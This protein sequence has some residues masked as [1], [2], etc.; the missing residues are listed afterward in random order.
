MSSMPSRFPAP[1]RPTAQQQQIVDEY[2][3][4]Y[5]ANQFIGE[6]YESISGGDQQ[7]PATPSLHSRYTGPEADNSHVTPGNFQPRSPYQASPSEY[8]P[9]Q[10]L[11]SN[12]IA[13]DAG[14]IIQ[15][16]PTPQSRQSFR[17]EDLH[18]NRPGFHQPQSQNSYQPYAVGHSPHLQGLDSSGNKSFLSL[19][20]EADHSSCRFFPPR[21]LSR[22]CLSPSRDGSTKVK[23]IPPAY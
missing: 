4:H 7:I 10:Q 12:D 3:N 18:A 19:A 9:R 21:L 17:F 23:V 20:L 8:Q 16:G 2:G 5:V 11:V 1:S 14:R 6:F 13:S 22:E 15:A